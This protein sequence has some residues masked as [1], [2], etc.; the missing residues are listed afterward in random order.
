MPNWKWIV[1]TSRRLMIVVPCAL[2]ACGGGGDSTGPVNA[3]STAVGAA[4]SQNIATSSTA[5]TTTPT[6]RSAV[7]DTVTSPATASQSTT[8]STTAAATNNMVTAS[9]ISTLPTTS[10]VANNNTNAQ[11]TN[12]N[13]STNNNANAVQPTTSKPIASST[14]IQ[15]TVVNA[16]GP[17]LPSN[18]AQRQTAKTY[19]FGSTSR[20]YL[21]YLPADY[22]RSNKTYPL[23]IFFH[24]SGEAASQSGGNVDAVKNFGP[25]MWIDQGHDMCFAVN[26][27]QQCFIVVSPQSLDWST[28]AEGVG[29]LEWAMSR[30]R[31]DTSRIYVTGLSMGGGLAWTMA[32]AKTS[33]GQVV[34]RQLAALAPIAGLTS[35]ETL[36]C[37]IAYEQLPVWAFHGLNDNVVSP[38]Y[39][40]R[41][42]G[43]LNGNPING[44]D[45]P[46]SPNASP[47][48]RLTLLGGNGQF[49][50][51]Y[52]SWTI[53]YDPHT[54]VEGN[55]NLYQWLL[56]QHR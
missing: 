27:A 42:V 28:N 13:A 48:A 11:N 19:R 12:N 16:S 9:N 20:Q 8:T 38:D 24:G 47:D 52:L 51:H 26:G 29:M 3:T 4:V 22:N 7:T 40:R 23:L 46:C 55:K 36:G 54:Q 2:S 10:N 41:I 56:S 21:E 30:Y 50:D 6:T 15:V 53:A 25:P 45:R 32:S 43:L 33:T 35:P 34:A 17:D 37:N 18:P 44:A 5:S 49:V 31:V 39:S 14:V 1:L